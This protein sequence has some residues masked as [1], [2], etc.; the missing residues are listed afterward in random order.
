[1]S[2]HS[3][4][5]EN[6]IVFKH[7]HSH[8]HA[9]QLRYIR[10][11]SHN[12]FTQS[13]LTLYSLSAH[14]SACTLLHLNSYIILYT[15][16]CDHS[17][18]AWSHRRRSVC[19]LPIAGERRWL[20]KKVLLTRALALVLFECCMLHS[21]LL[22]DVCIQ[23]IWSGWILLLINEAANLMGLWPVIHQAPGHRLGP[24]R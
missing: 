5:M 19:C 4:K 21:Q 11:F 18:V 10:T 20:I 22:W 12:S 1:M 13:Q 15:D 14:E 2:L 17:A 3:W 23:L 24:L 16:I 8:I 6:A 9:L 7:T